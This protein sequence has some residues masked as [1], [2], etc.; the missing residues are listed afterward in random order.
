MEL[1]MFLTSEA[2]IIICISLVYYLLEVYQM[3][4][5]PTRHY[6][7]EVQNLIQLALF[8]LCMMFAFPAGH[9]SWYISAV[10]RQLGSIAVFLA[11]LNFFFLLKHTPGV[12]FALP[13]IIKISTKF[14]RLKYTL[15]RLIITPAFPLY[16]LHF[17]SLDTM[18]TEVSH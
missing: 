18:V 10:R 1:M 2:I 12:Q 4:Q 6:F 11:W 15:I 7:E 8:P 13:A 9:E 14:T 16:M 5:H 3:L 17:Q